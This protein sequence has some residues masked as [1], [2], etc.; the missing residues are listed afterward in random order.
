MPINHPIPRQSVVTARGDV[1][2]EHYMNLEK[3]K[4]L[5]GVG[6]IAQIPGKIKVDK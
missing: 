6:T 1:K 2:H 4:M 5:S 3:G